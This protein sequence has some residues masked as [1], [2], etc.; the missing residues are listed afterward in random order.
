MWAE[1]ERL[2]G[3]PVSRNSVKSYHR[4]GPY[5]LRIFERGKRDA[6][7]VRQRHRLLRQIW[8]HRPSR[9][10][11]LSP[12]PQWDRLVRYRPNENSL[13]LS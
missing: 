10:S 6:I 7:G 1:I 11:Y 12:T 2:L 8:L 5:E 3:E 9:F 4:R 13:K